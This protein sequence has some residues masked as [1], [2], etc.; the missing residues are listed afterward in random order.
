VL[1]DRSVSRRH[2]KIQKEYDKVL[3]S[4]LGSLNKT[5]V[6]GME[7]KEP[8]MLQDR[9]EIKLG[10]V[11]L[12]YT[13]P[14]EVLLQQ[15]ENEPTPVINNEVKEE[16]KPQ[17]DEPEE[18]SYK[19]NKEDK[20]EDKDKN[21]IGEEQKGSQQMDD[22]TTHAGKLSWLGVGLVVIFA[23]IG[24]GAVVCFWIILTMF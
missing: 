14:E 2:A 24:I 19:D 12:I 3:I 16:L 4:D 8:Y 9:D 11:R 1:S 15:L 23:V 22:D 20:D 5:M 6:N 10:N 7:I 17:Y 13:N 21:D 18:Y